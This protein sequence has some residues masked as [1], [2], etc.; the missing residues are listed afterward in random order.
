MVLAL[1]FGWQGER[2]T[3][4]PRPGEEVAWPSALRAAGG[5]VEFLRINDLG[6]FQTPG[7]VEYLARTVRWLRRDVWAG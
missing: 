2:P 4:R 6:H 7:Y 3:D 5:R 1:H